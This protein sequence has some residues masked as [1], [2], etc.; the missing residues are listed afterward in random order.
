ME[1]SNNI[2]KIEHDNCRV[3]TPVPRRQVPVAYQVVALINGVLFQR[4]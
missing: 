2:L 3:Q 4:V 1:L